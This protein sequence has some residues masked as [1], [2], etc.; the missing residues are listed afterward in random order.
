MKKLISLFII[1]ITM[2]CSNSDDNNTAAYKLSFKLDG[3]STNFDNVTVTSE[4][5]NSYLRVEAV[6]ETQLVS[7]LLT[8]ESSAS[9]SFSGFDITENGNFYYQSD[10]FSSQ[11]FNVPMNGGRL[12]GQFSGTLN[13]LDAVGNSLPSR[14][15]TNGQFDFTY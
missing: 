14:S 3:V 15:V 9:N 6:N 1:C 12:K 11:V 2:S 4:N 7:F 8:P 5:N 13:S 10:S